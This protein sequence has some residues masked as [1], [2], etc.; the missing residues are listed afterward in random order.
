MGMQARTLMGA[1]GASILREATWRAVRDRE[2]LSGREARLLRDG[3]AVRTA[4]LYTGR[5]GA[6]G[7]AFRQMLDVRFRAGTV[8]QPLPGKTP[9]TSIMSSQ[10]RP[11]HVN[12]RLR[13]LSA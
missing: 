13:K 4:G 10:Y 1:G 11:R 12:G 9:H 8:R 6:H 7:I 3:P 5:Q 2:L